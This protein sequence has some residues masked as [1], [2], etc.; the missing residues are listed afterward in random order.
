MKR[1][2]SL[3]LLLLIVFILPLT[4]AQ[5]DLYLQDSLELQL[6]VKGEFSLIPTSSSSS[7][8][9]TEAEIFLVPTD[10]LRQEILKQTINPKNNIIKFT[11]NNGRTGTK[12]FG[13]TSNVKTKNIRQKVGK[14][15]AFPIT[16]IPNAVTQYLEETETIDS[17]HPS[18]I[19]KATQLAEGE[20]D[21]F[22]VVFKLASWVE[23]TVDYDLNTLTA[24]ASQKASWVLRNKEGVCDE[25]TSLFIAMARSLGIPARFVKGISYS[26]SDLFDNPWQ[27][28][29]WAEVY[30]P[31]IGWVSFDVTFGEYG[32]LDVTHI[33]LRDGFDPQDPDTKYKW[34][35]NNVDLVTK[36][37][38]LQVKINKLGNPIPEEI[39][40]KEEVFNKEVDFGSYNLIKGTLSNNADYYVATTLQIAIPK[41]IE[42]LGRNKRTILLSPNEERETYWILKV[43]ENLDP[44]FIY[45]FPVIIYSEKNV[46]FREEFVA[47]QDGPSYSE[48]EIRKLT[49][50][51]E[52][53]VYSRLIKISC[54]GKEEIKLNENN[55]VI[56]EVKNTGN[57][58]LE[59]VN[60]CLEENCSKINLPI[61][62]IS[63]KTINILG[64]KSGWNKVFV[65]AENKFIEK[66]FNFNYAVLDQPLASINFQGPT[67]IKFDTEDSLTILIG[68]ESF[69][70]LR[71][72]EIVINGPRIKNNWYAEELKQ[73]ENLIINL[74][75]IRIGSKNKFTVKIK[76]QDELGN[77]LTKKESFIIKGEPRNGKEKIKM[78]FNSILNLF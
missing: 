39:S 31:T 40:L 6:D 53:K 50:Q 30:F 35:A 72:V 8:K 47:S 54:N 13:Y 12:T 10:T 21:L 4:I 49:I 16:S 17:T 34:V 70:P 60:F 20:D 1:G 66:R 59:E 68:K 77:I 32:Y 28:H 9:S 46:S 71:K 74:S 76:W 33:K 19:A 29:G 69:S 23:E 57:T 45:T 73:T 11:W 43:P 55:K 3:T 36:P 48:A 78:F 52:D 67:T 24:K 63:K 44:K 5:D 42:I 37:L 51:D 18:I 41:E 56:C 61:N 15:I 75:N 2:T 27:P 14:K 26:T 25:M 58:N 62:Q 22:K 38:D 64:T 7:I 65:T